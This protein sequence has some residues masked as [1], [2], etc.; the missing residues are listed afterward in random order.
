ML[1]NDITPEVTERI[2]EEVFPGRK[3]RKQRQA[4]ARLVVV[5]PENEVDLHELEFARAERFNPS[6]F[7]YDDTRID[8]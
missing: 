7:D 1:A 6:L 2:L 4:R 8:W 5:K 3:H